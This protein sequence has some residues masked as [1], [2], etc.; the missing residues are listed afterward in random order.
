VERGSKG[1]GPHLHLNFPS[2]ANRSPKSL[3]VGERPSSSSDVVPDSKTDYDSSERMF[4][5]SAGRRFGATRHLWTESFIVGPAA[6]ADGGTRNGKVSWAIVGITQRRKNEKPTA[7]EDRFPYSDFCR[8]LF[9]YSVAAGVKVTDEG[10]Q[11]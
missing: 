8:R 1:Y 4:G 9:G 6:L 10:L 5:V 2:T 7:A 3:I 11:I